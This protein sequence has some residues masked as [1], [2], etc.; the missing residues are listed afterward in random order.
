MDRYIAPAVIVWFTAQWFGSARKGPVLTQ[1]EKKERATIE[2]GEP[3]L[4][5]GA[6]GLSAT[7]RLWSRVHSTATS[8][9]VLGATIMGLL[10]GA[11]SAWVRGDVDTCGGHS[12]YYGHGRR[13]FVDSLIP[14]PSRAGG[15]LS[16]FVERWRF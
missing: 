2:G 11:V 13:N 9:D 3:R 8:Q 1:Q 4:L 5:A 15:T 6:C 14:T 12:S 16:C 10:T 7:R